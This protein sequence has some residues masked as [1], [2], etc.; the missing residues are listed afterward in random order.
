[1]GGV[2]TRLLPLSLIILPLLKYIEPK[3]LTDPVTP[4]EP[5][6]CALPVKGKGEV[7]PSR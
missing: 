3:I 5:V 1:V 2:S 6:I 4:N 7:Y